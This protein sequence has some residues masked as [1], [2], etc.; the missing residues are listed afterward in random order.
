MP[1]FRVRVLVQCATPGVTPDQQNALVS[2]PRRM[3]YELPKELAVVLA[4]SNEVTVDDADLPESALAL[5][6]AQKLVAATTTLDIMPTAYA[7]EEVGGTYLVSNSGSHTFIVARR[8]DSVPS[9]MVTRQTHVLAPEGAA[10]GAE[11]RTVQVE[12][13]C[14]LVV[15]SL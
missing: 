12:F 11:P 5:K 4:N 10:A 1:R 7:H 2:L 15:E 9:P 3:L 14:H 8:G 13:R 6:A